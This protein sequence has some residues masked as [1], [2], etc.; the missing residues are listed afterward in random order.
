MKIVEFV[1]VVEIHVSEIGEKQ[2]MI[3]VM[4]KDYVRLMDGNDQ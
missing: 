4:K 3:R 2:Y 1:S